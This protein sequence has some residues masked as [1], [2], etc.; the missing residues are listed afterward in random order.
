MIEPIQYV[1][2]YTA[3]IGGPNLEIASGPFTGHL[4]GRLEMVADGWKVYDHSEE[5]DFY[6]ADME[7]ALTWATGN[8]YRYVAHR[9]K[10]G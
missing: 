4:F 10:N 7:L 6:T 1:I 3:P 9:R 8:A 2:R 5:L